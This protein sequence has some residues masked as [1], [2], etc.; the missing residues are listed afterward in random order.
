MGFTVGKAKPR[1]L[2]TWGSSP[3]VYRGHGRAHPWRAV[4]RAPHLA[5]WFVQGR[6][7]QDSCSAGS[8]SCLRLQGNRA[9]GLW[10]RRSTTGFQRPSSLRR[11]PSPSSHHSQPRTAAGACGPFPWL[12]AVYQPADTVGTSISLSQNQS[13]QGGLPFTPSYSSIHARCFRTGVGNAPGSVG[14]GEPLVLWWIRA[15]HVVG[16]ALGSVWLSLS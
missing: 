7:L 10:L 11:D 6:S 15:G 12:K 3:K 14:P 2:Q 16:R 4:T 9:S 8:V 13:E 5:A 1:A